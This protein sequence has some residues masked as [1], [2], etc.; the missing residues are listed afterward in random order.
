MPRIDH[1]MIQ[2]MLKRRPP[3]LDPDVVAE[4]H[5]ALNW[6]VGYEDREWDEVT[7]DT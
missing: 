7:T 4:W 3:Q 2:A 5:Y 6:R 1:P